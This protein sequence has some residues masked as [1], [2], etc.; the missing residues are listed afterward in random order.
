MI[1]LGAFSSLIWLAIVLSCLCPVVLV[2]MFL[3]DFKK[4]QLW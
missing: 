4:R 1:S 2:V 3:I